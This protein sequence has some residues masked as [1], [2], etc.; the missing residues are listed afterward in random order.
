[1]S[2]GDVLEPWEN[3]PEGTVAPLWRGF[4]PRVDT[5]FVRCSAI[6]TGCLGAHGLFRS[7]G[8]GTVGGK[9]VRWEDAGVSNGS[10]RLDPLWADNHGLS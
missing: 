5:V 6:S 3:H 7:G 9:S 8:G 2:R 4:G 10:R 1:M